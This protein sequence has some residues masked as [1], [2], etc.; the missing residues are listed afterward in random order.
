MK[1]FLDLPH[2]L[3]LTFVEIIHRFFKMAQNDIDYFLLH[4]LLEHALALGLLSCQF[5]WSLHL[6]AARFLSIY[7]DTKLLGHGWIL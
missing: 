5:F 3:L 7:P 6:F 1:A 2:E 4:T